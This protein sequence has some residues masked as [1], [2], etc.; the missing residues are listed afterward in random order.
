MLLLERLDERQVRLGYVNC[1]VLMAGRHLDTRQ[2]LRRRF[3]AFVFRKIYDGD[4]EGR[5]F[6]RRI[7]V[8]GRR[9]L[10]GQDRQRSRSRGGSKT[11][12]D[13]AA[14]LRRAGGTERFRYTSHLWLVQTC[15]PS[16]L[17]PLAPDRSE[18]FLEHAKHLGFLAETYALTETGYVLQQL[19]LERDAGIRDGR[20]TPNPMHVGCRRGVRA[21]YL[22]SLLERDAI[23]PFLLRE[24]LS[25]EQ[26]DP[27]L[28]PVA[29]QALIAS[30]ERGLT[31][32]SALELRHLRD[33]HRRVE[34]GVKIYRHHV[35]PRLEHYV[36]LELLGRR[37]ESHVADT[38]YEPTL[39]AKRAVEVWS[40]L[41]EDPRGVRG[42]RRF[43][44]RTFFSATAYIFG[45]KEARVCDRLEALLYFAKGFELVGREIGFTPGRTVALAA[46][47][48]ALEQDR[49]LEIDTIFD[50]VYEAARSG[51][52][53]HLTFSGG[54]RFDREFLIR[55]RP[56]LSALLRAGP[57]V[58][59]KN[60]AVLSTAGG[61]D[62]RA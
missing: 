38:V 60:P 36:D 52:G 7:S 49:I 35:R 50:I 3:D 17:G 43:L 25:R 53:E 8:E 41:L 27:K 34:R 42:V 47:L 59:L 44:D 1:V 56:E 11:P 55:V 33:Y 23:T 22:R 29:T 14:A 40:T 9:S 2:A 10:E 12:R 57:D 26:N 51:W 18:V 30:F 24:V 58:G 4:A 62:G 37:T 19:L 13:P 5:E 15:M 46:C 48:L 20:A 61:C 39:A 21:L 45:L 28:L 6:D 32:E 54:S 31:V 16:H